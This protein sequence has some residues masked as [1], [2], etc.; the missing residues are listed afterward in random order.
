MKVIFL[1]FDGVLNSALYARTEEYQK[2]AGGASWHSVDSLKWWSYGLD[3]VAVE[4]LNSL[5]ER[6]GA[7][8]VISSSWRL[9]ATQEW[10]VQIL[11]SRGFTGEVVGVTPAYGGDE[12]RHK[13][14]EGWIET[15]RPEG[16]VVIDDDADAEIAGRFVYTSSHCGLTDDDVDEAVRILEKV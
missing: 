16:Y 13:E 12:P 5:V 9:G 6:T 7:K 4:R 15:H 3:S 1:D 2:H 10:L 8:V 14:I 11:T